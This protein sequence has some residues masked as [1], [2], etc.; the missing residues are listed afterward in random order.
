M[1]Q[2]IARRYELKQRLGHGAMGNVYLALDRLTSQMIA[3]KQVRVQASSLDFGAA[4]SKVS[5]HHGHSED[6]RLALAMEFRT[7][8]S[9]RHPYIVSVLDYGFD[10]DEGQPFFAMQYIE[11]GKSLTKYALDLDASA[12]IAL[13]TQLLQ[14][15]AYL[16]RRE[17]LHRDLKPQNVLVSKKVGLKVLD[18]GLALH[19][20]ESITNLHDAGAGTLPYLAP[21]IFEE[22]SASVQSD[23]YAVG[24][25]AY[26][27]M[28]GHYPYRRANMAAMV[29]SIMTDTPDTSN[30]D[31]ELGAVLDRLLS[32]DPQ[33]RYR[34][35]DEVLEALCTATGVGIPD[36]DPSLRE[37]YLQSAR[38]VGRDDALFDLQ[39]ALYDTK[40]GRGS[41]WLIAGESG[42]GKT[43][44][45]E[46][47][48]T[49]ALV[50]GI[51]VLKGQGASNEGLPYEA[52][53]QVMRQLLLSV[54]LG[55]AELSILRELLP[56]IE[57]L[58]DKLIPAAAP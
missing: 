54:D 35:A 50:Q 49:R 15:L 20:H 38:F 12:K 11:N 9:L 8:A 37:S 29:Q 17:I 34:N 10:T 55:E 46:E 6:Y 18:F 53:R 36:E 32:K 28:V 33:E 23:L 13:L 5:P 41:A 56:N 39:D 30:L 3:L 24:V 22:K 14:A 31:D 27:L 57:N 52:W 48:R 19:K 51:H 21:E 40:I 26:E 45:L 58:L 47:V 1:T 7:L 2:V 44:L 25:M 4:T 16:H 42:V 43:R